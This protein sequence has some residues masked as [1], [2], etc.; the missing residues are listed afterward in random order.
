MGVAYQRSS[1]HAA[2]PPLILRVCY[3]LPD[4]ATCVGFS[5]V[6]YP[7]MTDTPLAAGNYQSR[8]EV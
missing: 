3:V 7:Y 4:M 1:A 5:V 6:A 2:P 8:M